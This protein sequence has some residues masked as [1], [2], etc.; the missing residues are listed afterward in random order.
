V[1]SALYN[2]E[3]GFIEVAKEIVLDDDTIEYA[4]QSF[5]PETLEWLAAVY[6]THDLD[7]LVDLVLYEPHVENISP[8][9]ISAE[10]ARTL[11]KE[12][13]DE[14]KKDKKPKKAASKA[15]IAAALTASPVDNKFA[16]AA[17]E[18]PLDFIKR[19]CPF[20]VEAVR[21]KHEHVSDIRKNFKDTR[22]Q[23]RVISDREPI[24]NRLPR[25]EP[26][27]ELPPVILEGKKRK[28]SV[29]D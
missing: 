9:Q 26:V 8:L 12:K 11:H 15:Q 16:A 28:N 25:S 3:T 29:K 22:T 27:K 6:D 4:G 14:F 20:D 5:H 17:E 23:K 2:E 19:T 7:E 18:D 21:A 13:I 24:R 1:L 10:A